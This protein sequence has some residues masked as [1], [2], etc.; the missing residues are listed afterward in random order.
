MSFFHR[1]F[2]KRLPI[3]DSVTSS[4]YE[5]LDYDRS[6]LSGTSLAKQRIDVLPLSANLVYRHPALLCD[7]P[8]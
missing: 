3:C 2:I 8:F 1:G 5:I 6:T 7:R 4:N